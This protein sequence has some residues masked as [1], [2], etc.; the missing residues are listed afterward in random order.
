MTVRILTGEGVDDRQ[1]H[2]NRMVLERGQIQL[3]DVKDY[4]CR[5][6]ELE[7]LI[8]V[9]TEEINEK[10]AKVV[11]RS[12][13]ITGVCVQSHGDPDGMSNTLCD[14]VGLKKELEKLV[15]EYLEMRETYIR[16]IRGLRNIHYIKILYRVYINHMDLKQCAVDIQMGYTTV[17]QKHEK[18]LDLFWKKYAKEIMKAEE[19]EEQKFRKPKGTETDRGA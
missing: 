3:M 2:Q 9:L 5:L 6:H 14:V 17:L 18:A 16:Q 19:D 7:E 15:K 12:K 11:N 10:Y 1:I 4:L 13:Q 8:D